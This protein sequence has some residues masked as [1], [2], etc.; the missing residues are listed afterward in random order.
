MHM[1][2]TI[3]IFSVLLLIAI[4]FEPVSKQFKF[5]FSSLLVLVGF[6]GS[7]LI[8]LAG[9]DTGLRWDDFV[10]IILHFLVPIIVF[11]SAFNANFKV[12]RLNIGT[13]LYLAIP[14]MFVASIITGL[15]LFIGIGNSVGFP[16]TSALL[17]GIILSAT[18][19]VAVV[20]I[21]KKLGAPARLTALLEGESLFNDATAIVAYTLLVS[22]ALNGSGM[23]TAPSVIMFFLNNA[24]G[25]LVVGL[26]VS[27]VASKLYSLSTNHFAYALFGILTAIFS[28]YFAE[29][30]LHVSGI[31][32]VLAGGLYLGEFYRN[33]QTNNDTFSANLW[34]LNAYI[35]N[36]I[37]FILVG[38]TITVSMFTGQW[39][40]ML[41]GI[42]AAT[43]ARAVVVYG[44][45]PV[46]TFIPSVEKIGSRSKNV[47]MWGGLRGAVS[48]ALALSI[49]TDIEG[50]Y[51]IQSIVYG[52][53][54]FTLFVQAPFMEKLVLKLKESN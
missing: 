8:V 20:D 24:L 25:G 39:L 36:A 51:T 53:V 27:Y 14:C 37:L 23:Q 50:W 33:N 30:L 47:M 38:V 29:H 32:S 35:A 6:I 26:L 52:V 1:I 13:V 42:L 54:I 49:P 9:F 41:I 10:G 2:E 46:F 19:P 5:P 40:A 31:V 18:D 45:L 22:F 12:L 3:V 48:L 34:E 7:E 43:I 28:F 4:L 21:F 15:I 16:I 44:C 17:A 11:E